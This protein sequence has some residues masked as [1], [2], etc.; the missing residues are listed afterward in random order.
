MNHEGKLTPYQSPGETDK[1]PVQMS[2]VFS[3]LPFPYRYGLL[4]LLKACYFSASL[5]PVV[6]NTQA[7]G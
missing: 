1:L 4:K 2:R 5:L 6:F 7:S 3:G